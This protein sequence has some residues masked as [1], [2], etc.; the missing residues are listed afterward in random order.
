MELNE[1]EIK[2]QDTDSQSASM[3]QYRFSQANNTNI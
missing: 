1:I 3:K 2:Q